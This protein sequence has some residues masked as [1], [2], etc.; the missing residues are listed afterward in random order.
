MAETAVTAL[1]LEALRQWDTPTICNGLELLGTEYRNRG[2]T[3]EH[4]QCFDPELP[5]IVG[6]ARTAMIRSTA[7]A[8]GTPDEVRDMRAAYY[9][10]IA[11]DP[12][13]SI[14]VI[15]DLDPVPGFG[16]FWGR[17]QHRDPPG[18][19]LPWAWS[20]TGRSGHRRLCAG[21]P[22]PRGQGR[23][24]PCLGPPGRDRLRGQHLRNGC[25]PRRHHPRGPARRRGGAG[26]VRQGA[27][28]RHRR[29]DT[30]GGGDPRGG[31]RAG[32]HRG[33]PAPG[34]GGFGRN[35]LNGPA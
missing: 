13:P 2:F 16:A 21:V 23:S 18:S 17:G 7:P 29:A 1:E 25:A 11:A 15:Q 35:P 14:S 32:L 6:Y 9:E 30:P 24:E 27:S 26:R 10:T 8:A 12:A 19:R 22:A 5:P 33:D 3:I 4:M 31:A 34:H 28:G 20:P